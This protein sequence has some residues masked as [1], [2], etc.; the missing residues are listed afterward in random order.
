[1]FNPFYALIGVVVPIKISSRRYFTQQLRRYGVDV[2]KIP[3]GCLQELADR[4]VHLSKMLAKLRGGNWRESVTDLLEG[5][6]VNIAY[7]LLDDR[8]VL[9]RPLVGDDYRE[10][11]VPILAKYGVQVPASTGT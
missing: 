1:M 7:L 10:R 4:A 11:T 2:S 8:D 5:E 3:E 6:A 9:G